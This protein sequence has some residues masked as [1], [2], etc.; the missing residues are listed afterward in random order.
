MNTQNN[1]VFQLVNERIVRKGSL[2]EG[3]KIRIAA[4]YANNP[5]PKEAVEFLKNEYGTGG[6]SLSGLAG[7]AK[8][9]LDFNRLGFSIRYDNKIES[10]Y[11]WPDIEKV[12]RHLMADGT[13]LTEEEHEKLIA[14]R[15]GR[16]D[17]SLPMPIAR[18]AYPPEN[19]PAPLTWD[20]FAAL[21]PD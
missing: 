15:E 8:A 4:F 17:R 21:I 20:E 7:G 11:M 2:Y 1:N 10:Y 3:G 9:F 18:Y 19:E 12:I 6:C 16:Y 5:T 13:Y 14:I